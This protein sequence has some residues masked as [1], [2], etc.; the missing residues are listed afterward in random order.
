MIYL[1]T[2][3]LLIKF[4]KN[5]IYKTK[6]YV[7]E[8][9][10]VKRVLK[11]TA[12]SILFVMSIALVI[13]G[14]N[15]LH[16]T[17]SMNKQQSRVFPRDI[18]TKISKMPAQ[19]TETVLLVSDESNPSSLPTK[20]SG[21]ESI[22]TSVTKATT[23]ATTSTTVS[24]TSTTTPTTR[25]T[26]TAGH[27]A[28]T[29]KATVDSVKEVRTSYGI[30]LT[31]EQL[32]RLSILIYREAGSQSAECQKA[33]TSCFFNIMIAEGKSFE[34]NFYC[35]NRYSPVPYLID[36]FTEA[37]EQS[38]LFQSVHQNVKDVCENGS[39][40]PL[41]VMYFRNQHYHS[42]GTPY[43]CIDGVYFSSR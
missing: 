14:C 34:E 21:K 26:T 33:V 36:S 2:L 18:N 43:D 37:E 11:E 8:H 27:T 4:I 42:F 7:A 22:K 9:S 32:H 20:S 17:S 5:F 30:T 35:E 29:T 12:R 38:S 10:I 13:I 31:E 41:S 3:F 1:A 39:T 28:S 40:V 25:A 19:L 15:F 24:T 23:V 6:N 16:G